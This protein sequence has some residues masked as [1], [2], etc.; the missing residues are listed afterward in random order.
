MSGSLALAFTP[1]GDWV[2]LT[3]LRGVVGF[4]VGGFFVPMMLLQ[5]FL[6]ASRRGQ[7]GHEVAYHGQP[8][9][10]VVADTVEQ[11]R[12]A[13]RAVVVETDPLPA[14]VGIRAAIDALQQA[15]AA[16]R[17]QASG[18]PLGALHG[19][20]VGIKDIIDTADM[21][22][23]NGTVLHAGRRPAKDAT[24]VARLRAAGAVIMGKTNVPAL[25]VGTG[26]M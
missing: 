7:V 22:T 14:I 3:L 16:D 15:R 9:A 24:V 18:A 1:E 21:P 4:G 8:L 5:E 13:S 17:L 26:K 10:L 19:V 6:P 12:A 25:S 11:A 23:E 20:P 2:Y